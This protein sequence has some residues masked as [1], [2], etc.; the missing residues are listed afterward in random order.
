MFWLLNLQ[1]SISTLIDFTF[2]ALN[3]KSITL[4]EIPFL[5]VDMILIAAL[6]VTMSVRLYVSLSV[7]L[8]K[9][10]FLENYIS[11]SKWKMSDYLSRLKYNF[12]NQ[13]TLNNRPP[14]IPGAYVSTLVVLVIYRFTTHYTQICYQELYSDH[15]RFHGWGEG[16]A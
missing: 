16:L 9:K 8:W 12:P 2:K 14:H 13:S 11:V 3:C 6:L 4:I 10:E 7:C 15:G 1:K 5:L